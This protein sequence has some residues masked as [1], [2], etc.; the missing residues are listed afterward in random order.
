M[1]TTK[2][3]KAKGRKLQQYVR[4]KILEYYPE[5]YKDD[6]RST[7]MGASGVDILLSP[8]A[9]DLFPFSIECK[10]YKTFAIYKLFEQAYNNN[11]ELTPLL[12]IKGNNQKP[13]VILEF[14][15]FMNLLKE[16]Y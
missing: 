6:V 7:S 15:D 1:T 10:S 12:V 2:S 11:E 5:L 14:E 13:L 16:T 3:S 9:Q 8:F 4:D